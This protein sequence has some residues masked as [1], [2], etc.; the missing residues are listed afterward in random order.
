MMSDE[1]K[2][3]AIPRLYREDGSVEWDWTDDLP[4]EQRKRILHNRMQ[5]QRML[6]EAK[7]K[8]AAE[9]KKD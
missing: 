5:L 8:R 9:Q 6:A 4:E 2:S 7:R 3:P 1:P